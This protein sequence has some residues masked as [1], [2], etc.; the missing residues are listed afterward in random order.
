MAI[1]ICLGGKMFFGSQYANGTVTFYVVGTTYL[2]TGVYTDKAG[3]IDADNPMTLDEYGAASVFLATDAKI[4]VKT[5]DDT[6][7]YTQDGGL[8]PVSTTETNDNRLTNG[9]AEI[10]SDA[11]DIPDGWSVTEETDSTNERISSDQVHGAYCFKST[12]GGNGGGVWLHDNYVE[13]SEND[14]MGYDFELKS[15]NAD[16]RNVVDVLWYDKDKNQLSGGDASTNLLDDNTTNSTSWDRKQGV[17]TPPATAVYCRPRVTL[18]ASSDAS[19]GKWSQFDNFQLGKATAVHYLTTTGDLLYADAAHSPARLSVPSEGVMY[20]SVSGVPKS[21]LPDDFITGLVLSNDAGDTDNDI[22][23]TAGMADSADH[24]TALF[25]ASEITKQI[26]ATWSA[27]D[28]AG[29]LSSS[30]DPVAVDTWYHVFLV[31]IGGS[32]DVLFDTSLTC[33]NGVAD[34]SVTAYR[35]IGSIFTEG[36]LT[37]NIV[38]FKQI[39]DMFLYS[40]SQLDVSTNNPGTSAVTPTITTPLGIKTTA[41]IRFGLA[42]TSTTTNF[43]VT[44]PDESDQAPSVTAAPLST[45][46]IRSSDVRL[47]GHIAVKTNTSS[48]IRYRFAASSTAIT[49]Y[50]ATYGYIDERTS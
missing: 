16:V 9:S 38:Q 12:D 50:F 42:T 41:L 11:D 18:C 4:V 6:T 45:A 21:G 39:G 2:H 46:Y 37:P 5:A 28:D 36:V 43:V 7:M 26:D 14:E 30:L 47:F 49:V 22:N 33:A 15:S 25:L 24:G 48:Q 31:E 44:S 32:V 20:K 17:V 29:G 27:G 3:Q 10:D 8:I 40:S 23:V 19:A 1:N 34:H 35:R 13:V